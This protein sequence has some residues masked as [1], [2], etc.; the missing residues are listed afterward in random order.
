MRGRPAPD[1]A[2]RIA[3][4]DIGSNS[5]RL[6]VAEVSPDASYRVI[7]DEK[8]IA[9]LGQG[10]AESGRLDVGRM[11]QAVEGIERLKSIADG[12]E[13]QRLRAVATA[14]VREATNGADLVEMV[15]AR[16]GLEVEIITADQ[17]ARLA[18][19]SVSNA[20]HL[21]EQIALVV[22]VGGGSTE[23]LLSVNGVVEQVYTLKL[24]AVRLTEMF[25]PNDPMDEDAFDRMRKYIGDVM[26]EHADRPWVTPHLMYG[27]GGTF[28]ALASM[29]MHRAAPD[30]S[31]G[32]MLPFTIRGYEM[33]RS[34]VRHLLDWLRKL[35]D[36]QRAGVPGLSPDRAGIIVAG[37]AIA[38]RVMRRFDVNRLTVHEGGIRDGLI[39]AMV[40][41]LTGKSGPKAKRPPVDRVRDVRRFAAKCNYEVRDSEHVAKLATRIFD[42]IRAQRP[43]LGG[44]LT[45]GARD[46]LEAGAVLRDV[47]YLVNY[48]GHH[49]HSYH[50]IVHSDLRGFSARE[51]EV[52][53]NVAR[54]HRKSEPKGKHPGYS[55]LD[56]GARVTVDALASIVRIADGLD[57]THTQSVRDVE[58]VMEGDRALFRAVAA[59]DP[60]VDLWGAEQ[61]AGMFARVFGVS[62]AFEWAPVDAIDPGAPE[63]KPEAVGPTLMAA[64]AGSGTGDGKK[65]ERD[66]S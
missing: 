44:V 40:D 34:E 7:D 23:I 3:A 31:A 26:R 55:A 45:D 60:A 22:D 4:L 54:Y 25:S 37:V 39:L 51:I 12:F 36:R 59:A 66:E 50:L 62:V 33:Q 15:R 10:L 28:T 13:V 46:M 24:G 49:K 57:R 38:D 17:E 48:T 20:F 18:Y 9:R 32:D 58:V 11:A 35:N 8:I 5:I 43:D 65:S 19:R 30:R 64:G 56:E 41:E 47:G 21:D 29:S 27:T 61:K 2:R 63:K 6:I 1:G 52:I 14:A 16:C 42:Q 53:A